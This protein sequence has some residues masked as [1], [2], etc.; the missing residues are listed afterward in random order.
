MFD[1]SHSGVLDNSFS[2][3][4][5]TIAFNAKKKGQLEYVNLAGC[6]NNP[7]QLISIYNNMNISEYD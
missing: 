5:L 3:I 1:I 4:G 2:N 6:I 7:T